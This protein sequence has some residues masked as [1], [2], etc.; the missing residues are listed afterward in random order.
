MR[1]TP[2][3]LFEQRNQKEKQTFD[4]AVVAAKTERRNRCFIKAVKLVTQLIL[5]GRPDVCKS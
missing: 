1:S 4:D 3:L 5:K 2:C